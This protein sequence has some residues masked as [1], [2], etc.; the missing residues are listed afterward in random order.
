MCDSV[1]FARTLVPQSTLR[2]LGWDIGA[3][4]DEIEGNIRE[5][6]RRRKENRVLTERSGGDYGA[7]CIRSCSPHAS[8]LHHPQVPPPHPDPPS[9]VDLERDVTRGFTDLLVREV[10]HLGAVEPRRDA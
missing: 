1:A 2:V 7:Y 4:Q 8:I 10:D 9:I 6:A 5:L 3:L